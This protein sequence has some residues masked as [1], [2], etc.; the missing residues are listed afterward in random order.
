[1]NVANAVASV[2][3]AEAVGVATMGAEA[4]GFETADA[5]ADHA[6]LRFVIAALLFGTTFLSLLVIALQRIAAAF[7]FSIAAFFKAAAFVFFTP[8]F[9][10]S[11]F[12]FEIFAH[13]AGESAPSTDS[14][15]QEL[16]CSES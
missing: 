16:Q 6:A 15:R 14:F 10:S 13:A 7:R 3:D 9:A 2:A 4:A 11:F 8:P 12:N 5:A 1:M